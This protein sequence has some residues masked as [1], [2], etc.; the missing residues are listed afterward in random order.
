MPAALL[1]GAGVVALPQTA[2]ARWVAE[3]LPASAAPALRRLALRLI[4]RRLHIP[5]CSRALSV[6]KLPAARYR[7]CA[8]S[9]IRS[10][11]ACP[12]ARKLPALEELPA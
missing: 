3:T 6:A 7:S 11:E 2:R 9:R 8:E 10:A 12:A 4:S 1:S 5:S